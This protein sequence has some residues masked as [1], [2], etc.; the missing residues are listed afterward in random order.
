MLLQ[1]EFL[2]NIAT[3]VNKVYRLVIYYLPINNS[4][5]FELINNEKNNND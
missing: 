2:T 4:Q 1:A 5:D 3:T